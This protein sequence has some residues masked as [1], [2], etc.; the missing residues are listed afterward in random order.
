MGLSD[1]NACLSWILKGKG[2]EREGKK[3]KEKGRWISLE[4][5]P[6]LFFYEFDG[7]DVH[8][9]HLDTTRET[10]AMVRRNHPRPLKIPRN[11]FMCVACV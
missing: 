11:A 2:R 4:Q 10:L 3:S 8:A 6:P 1:D 7:D 5:P 9:F